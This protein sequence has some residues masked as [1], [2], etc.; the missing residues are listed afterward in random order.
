MRLLHR[1]ATGLGMGRLGLTV[2]QQA[3]LQR[4]LQRPE[5]MI[6]LTGPTGSGKTTT[7]YAALNEILRESSRA[8]SIYTLEDPIEYDLLSIN[9]TSIEETFTYAQ[10][11]KSML[12][13][14]PDVIMVG[15]IRDLE[16]ARIALQAGMTGHLILTTVHAKSAAGVFERLIEMGGDPHSV[17]SAVTAV[18]GQ[19]LLRLLCPACKRPKPPGSPEEAQLA[20]GTRGGAFHGPAGCDACQGKGYRG[21][22]GLFELIEVDEALCRLIV[23][24]ASP[25]D[26]LREAVRRGTKTLTALGAELA[27]RGETSLEEVIRVAPAA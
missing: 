1:S 22:A 20:R 18:L 6:V 4:L 16:T 14:D 19:R 26:L 11:L 17:A 5:G 15:E 10:G 13:Q 23:E 24:R 27:A 21:R 8:R 2:D 9:Q 7:I 3:G 25:E 12:R